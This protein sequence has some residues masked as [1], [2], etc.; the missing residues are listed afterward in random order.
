[1]NIVEA[2]KSIIENGGGKEL[3]RSSF[4]EGATLIHDEKGWGYR[5][6]ELGKGCVTG[7][8]RFTLEDIIADDWET[9]S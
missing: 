7:P 3:R 4:D 9:V 2:C 8:F 1:M 5:V 6:G